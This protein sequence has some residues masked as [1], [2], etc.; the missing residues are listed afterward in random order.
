MNKPVTTSIYSLIVVILLA[1]SAQIEEPAQVV[2]PG[3]LQ[4]LAIMLAGTFA[5]WRPMLYGTLAY[6]LGGL[7]GIPWF[8]GMD[9]DMTFTGGY[10]MAFVAAGTLVG[11]QAEKGELQS[12]TAALGTYLVSLIVIHLGGTI[13]MVS[14]AGMS[15]TNAYKTGV[16]STLSGDIAEILIAAVVS[17]VYYSMRSHKS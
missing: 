10:I 11:W 8:S 12:F 13:W 15:L 1:I 2:V 9:A 4:C 5:G 6:A 3:T 7:A 14:V 17:S 16:E